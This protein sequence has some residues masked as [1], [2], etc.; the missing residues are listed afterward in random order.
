MALTHRSLKTQYPLD[1]HDWAR[2][3]ADATSCAFLQ[4]ADAFWAV[5]DYIFENQHV[6]SRLNLGEH[7]IQFMSNQKKFDTSRFS[8]CLS[9]LE[10]EQVRLDLDLAQKMRLSQTPSVFVNGKRKRGLLSLGGI[11]RAVEE[12]RAEDHGSVN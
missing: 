10:P 7:L 3:A 5:H 12:A 4:G 6:L 2:M 8:S 9:G 1:I 11:G